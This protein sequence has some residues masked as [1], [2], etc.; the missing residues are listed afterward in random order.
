MVLTTIGLIICSLVFAIGAFYGRPLLPQFLVAISLAISIIPEGLPATAT[1]V[2]ALGV[3]R[4]VKR[5]AC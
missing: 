5:N 3:K 2:M 1:I 4:M